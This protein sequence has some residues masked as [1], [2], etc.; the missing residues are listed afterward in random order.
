MQAMLIVNT[1][2]SAK[3]Q[4][5]GSVVQHPPHLFASYFVALVS[6]AVLAGC[7]PVFNWRD[8]RL[9][10][11]PVLALLPCK[12]DHA[13]RQI[14][15]P[16]GPT[17]LVMAGCQAGGATFA[18]SAMD[19]G[20]PLKAAE[21]ALQWQAATNLSQKS[22]KGASTPYRVPGAT[23]G[24]LVVSQASSGPGQAPKPLSHSLYFYQGQFVYQAQVLGEPQG[25]SDGPGALS[26]QVVETFLGG[27][28]L[29]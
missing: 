5:M 26:T 28:R 15:L 24:I 9:D 6:A 12:P 21:V 16:S 17:P 3:N 27:V 19:V 1:P 18:I 14:N 22:A 23:A 25:G 4:R 13:S 11:A 8:V 29:P 10:T 2:K 7:S 20:D